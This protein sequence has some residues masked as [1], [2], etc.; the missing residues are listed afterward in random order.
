MSDE[1]VTL[2]RLWLKDKSEADRTYFQDHHIAHNVEEIEL[3][4]RSYVEEYGLVYPLNLG[5]EMNDEM[6]NSFA[7][8]LATKYLQNVESSHCI[9]LPLM[10][11]SEPWTEFHVLKDDKKNNNSF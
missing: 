1:T 6:K 4:I 5:N 11:I 8:Y 7:L 2:I 9:P 10:H 3:M